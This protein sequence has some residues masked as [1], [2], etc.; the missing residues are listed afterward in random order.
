MQLQDQEEKFLGFCEGVV[1]RFNGADVRFHGKLKKPIMTRRSSV[2]TTSPKSPPSGQSS[3]LRPL[4]STDDEKPSPS[5]S[6]SSSSVTID[7]VPSPS[8]S[9]QISLP[10]SGVDA[11][12]ID[13]TF[14]VTSP[15][16][17]DPASPQVTAP[18]KIPKKA[19]SLPLF[20]PQHATQQESP[21]SETPPKSD[22]IPPHDEQ[23]PTIPEQSFSSYGDQSTRISVAY[24]E[25]E[26]GI[27]LTMLKALVNDDDDDDDD[28]D[29][30]DEDEWSQSSRNSTGLS[31]KPITMH[32]TQGLPP[33]EPIIPQEFNIP[34]RS[35]PAGGSSQEPV[36]QGHDLEDRRRSLAPSAA[37]SG[38]WEGAIYDDYRYSR[39]SVA[40]KASRFSTA[41]AFGGGFGS[42]NEQPPPIPETRPSLDSRP[43]L[44]VAAEVRPPPR[45]S[46]LDFSKYKFPN[47]LPIPLTPQSPQS[48]PAERSPL[49][50]TSWGSQTSSIRESASSLYTTSSNAGTSL[51]NDALNINGSPADEADRPS[52]R[53]L[54]RVSGDGLGAQIVIE[55]D[56]EIPSHIGSSTV[57]ESPPSSPEL[58]LDKSDSENAEPSTMDGSPVPK[59]SSSK[60]VENDVLQYLDHPPS[61]SPGLNLTAFPSP[62][63]TGAAVFPASQG[64]LRPSLAD[65][66]G[67]S[68]PGTNQRLSLFLPH[69]NA[70]KAPPVELSPGPMY[71]RSPR[72][73]STTMAGPPTRTIAT[74]GQARL[75]SVGILHVALSKSGSG[76]NSRG[77]T[78]YGRMETELAMSFGPV[79]IL[80]SVEPFPVEVSLLGSPQQHSSYQHSDSLHANAT[81]LPPRAASSSYQVPATS[82]APD[83]PIRSPPAERAYVPERPTTA[84][85]SAATATTATTTN[86]KVIPR[87]QLK[88]PGIRPRSQSL[89]GFDSLAETEVAVAS[90]PVLHKQIPQIIQRERARPEFPSLRSPTSSP[91]S[92]PPSLT[93][94]VAPKPSV[95]LSPLRPSPLPLRENSVG[96]GLGLQEKNERDNDLEPMSPAS[97]QASSQPLPGVASKLQMV[98]VSGLRISPSSQSPSGPLS[99]I[100]AATPDKLKAQPLVD[101][102]SA[103]ISSDSRSF[104]AVYSS[105]AMVRQNSLR[106]KLSLPNLRRHKSKQDETS[107]L[108]SGSQ[109]A[110]VDTVQVKDTDFELIRPNIPLLT[111]RNSEDLRKDSSLEPLS[112]GLTLPGSPAV[113]THSAHSP[114]IVSDSPS[115]QS[116]YGKNEFST[117]NNNKPPQEKEPDHLIDA[118]RQRELRW[119]SVMS[120]VLPTHSRK[121]KK[122]KKLLMEGVPASVRYLVWS[123]VTNGRAR[124]VT[125]VYAQLCS[126][127]RVAISNTIAADV[128]RCFREHPQ[129]QG[130]G[131][132]VLTV[133]QAY[134][135]MVPDIQYTTGLTM[136]VG[137]LLLQGPEEEVFWIFISLMDSYLRPYFSTNSIQLEVDATLFSRALENN[138]AQVARRILMDK[139]I[140]P[141]VICGDWFTSV[142]VTS[143]PTDYVNRVWDIFMYEGIPFLIR[144]GLAVISCCRVQILQ[145]GD[146][147]TL[148]DVIHHPPLEVLPPN[149]DALIALVLNQKLKDEDVRKQ[150]IK[151]EAQVKRQTQAQAPRRSTAASAISLPRF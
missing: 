31:Q 92:P 6:Y 47:R 90:L 22:V 13:H 79:P 3:T 27:G 46:S 150:R 151:M 107:S 56:E 102:D 126:R 99:P 140:P 34:R 136:I 88:T 131:S 24:S 75:N 42:S 108:G 48:P 10:T 35:L 129:L 91:L 85:T 44:D 64:H 78:I 130:P 117:P 100:D 148:L 61:L 26:V 121:T 133:L 30:G 94:G 128:E 110:E 118:H 41:S 87:P 32:M 69:P 18:L 116:P 105:T 54:S 93:V 43:N 96:G 103:S 14:S 138:D 145:A 74:G 52:S 143:L 72:E 147:K 55:D 7:S 113:S 125:G 70:P 33:N 135:N 63:P 86:R 21:R 119:I 71:I 5:M 4:P 50:H 12:P 37:S 49:L 17:Q 51:P 53:A 83:L 122:I 57:H 9:K 2:P 141:E 28:D 104:F 139:G 40:S 59:S 16:D 132:P 45:L 120:S 149:P 58:T 73:Q 29:D 124:I 101:T 114:T 1:G 62:P 68:I 95:K 97:P 123:H 106:S 39:Y 89:S 76:P 77:V 20:Q 82:P 81:G 109:V 11:S 66:R 98:E 111:N 127:G 112:A 115:W 23:L 80:F 19:P 8:N 25:A 15:P 142:F 137:Q 134:L 67:E 84:T 144:V 60:G 65:L 38:S 36:P 146:D